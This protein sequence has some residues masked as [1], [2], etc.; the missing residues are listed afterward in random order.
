MPASVFEEAEAAAAALGRCLERLDADLVDVDGAK[1]L[2]D[3]FT[4]CE[5]Y[6]VAGRGATARRVAKAVNWKRAGHRNPAEWLAGATGRSVAAAGRELDTARKLEELPETAAAFRAGELSEQQASEIAASA[7]LDPSSESRLL[8]TVRDGASFRTVRDECRETA[9]RATDDEAT[10]QWL[11]DTRHAH[12]GNTSAGHVLLHAELSPDL[13]AQVRSVLEKTTDALFREARREG[14]TELRSAY[15]ADA[16]AGVITGAITPPPV[17][18]RLH[19]DLAPLVRGYA[20]PGERCDLE[21]VGPIPVSMA[22]ALV[23]DSRVTLMGHDGKDIATVSSPTRTIPAR[24][25]RWVESAYPSCGKKGCDSTFRLQ[26]DHIQGVEDGGE[27]AKD[28]L[29]RLCHH[30]HHLKTHCGW[31]VERDEHGD[32]DLV[33]PD[34]T[35]APP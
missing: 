27:T 24:L 4:R 25:R 6:A 13:G 9:M 3:L 10:A 33:P 34:H 18:V 15:L 26:I 12:I 14:R 35:D 30:D 11:H 32:L 19:T 7:S 8:D 5:R 28:N 31:R 23:Q 1:R 17:E 2:V 29:W 22:R 16:V 21:G 20:E